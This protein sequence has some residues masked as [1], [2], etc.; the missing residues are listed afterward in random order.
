VTKAAAINRLNQK[1]MEEIN[2]LEQ[3]EEQQ[4]GDDIV[5]YH[6]DGVTALKMALATALRSWGYRIDRKKKIIVKTQG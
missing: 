4:V 5:A 6:R 2:F 1:L 3:C